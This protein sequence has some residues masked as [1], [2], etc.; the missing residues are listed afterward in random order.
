MRATLK[1]NNHPFYD[2]YNSMNY[3]FKQLQIGIKGGTEPAGT[4]IDKDPTLKNILLTNKCTLTEDTVFQM[5]E[6]ETV[7]DYAIIFIYNAEANEQNEYFDYIEFFDVKYLVVFMDWFKPLFNAKPDKILGRSPQVDALVHIAQLFIATST[8]YL[9]IRDFFGDTAA[10]ST[11]RI[12]PIIIAICI[13]GGLIPLTDKDCSAMKV[14]EVKE[15]IKN[16]P[17]QNIFCGMI[18]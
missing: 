3:A 7:K 14:S 2:F 12:S 5:L 6:L 17:I 13:I 18:K 8:N 11:D 16:N 9:A 1:S 4:E 10:A 15:I